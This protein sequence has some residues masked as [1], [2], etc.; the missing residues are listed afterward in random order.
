MRNSVAHWWTWD[1]P[2]STGVLLVAMLGLAPLFAWALVVERWMILAALVLVA[3]IPVVIRWPVLTTF[4]VYALLACSFDSLRIFEGSTLTK[5]VG[6][7]AAGVLAAVGLVERRLGRPPSTALWWGLFIVW[8]ALTTTWAINPEAGFRRLPSALSMFLLYLVGVSFKPTRR[9]LYWACVLTVLGGVLAAGAGYIFGL[10]ADAAG[11]KAR[12]RITLGGGDESNPN[13]LGR[14]LILPLAL[15]VGGLVG[16]PGIAQKAI[17]LGCIGLMGAGIFISMSR[18]ALLGMVTM[19]AVLVY[20]MRA[21]W[22][23][24]AAMVVLLMLSAVMPEQF[25]RRVVGMGGA[26]DHSAAERIR[27]LKAGLES[28]ENFGI[29]GIGLDNSPSAFTLYGASAVGVGPHNM[30]LMVWI[31]L[32]IIGLVLMLAAL[33]SQVFGVYKA[34]KLG[35]GGIV[36]AALEAAFLGTLTHAI[37]GIQIWTK[38]FWLILILL[39]WA[40]SYQRQSDEA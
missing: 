2:L 26:E 33:G 25:Y 35:H 30:Y 23:I 21:R 19:V 29:F 38:T 14:I 17:A 22:Q 4:G 15:G 28:I 18:A 13:T 5:P 20:R 32:G 7:L 11:N 10:D 40:T 37:F 27:L 6:V 3:L 31:E 34:R 36:L 8:A 24:I 1:L 16:L 9:E 12:G 39:T